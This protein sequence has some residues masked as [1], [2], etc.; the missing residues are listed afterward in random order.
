MFQVSAASVQSGLAIFLVL[1]YVVDRL[2]GSA[3]T[4]QLKRKGRKKKEKKRGEK[5]K[6][7]SRRDRFEI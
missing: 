2:S 3:C 7:K 6:E 1:V 4:L 5:K